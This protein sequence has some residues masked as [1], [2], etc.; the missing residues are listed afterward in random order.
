MQSLNNMRY[1]EAITRRGTRCT[2]LKGANCNY[3][4]QHR[5][6]SQENIEPSVAQS[7]STLL[8]VSEISTIK[9]HLVRQLE[10][11]QTKCTSLV[12]E[13]AITQ[14]KIQKLATACE[15]LRWLAENGGDTVFEFMFA[16]DGLL[17]KLRENQENLQQ[18]LRPA[19]T[20][21]VQSLNNLGELLRCD[22][23]KIF[24]KQT[25]NFYCSICLEDCVPN[26]TD[27]ALHCNHAFHLNCI[28]LHFERKL[29]CPNCRL[30]LNINRRIANYRRNDASVRIAFIR[31]VQH[32]T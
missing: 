5:S 3:C 31:R 22:W 9:T 4:Y 26:E 25:E 6:R 23:N 29:N 1:C 10:S 18:N 14:L 30:S 7:A 32:N 15:S 8:T 13:L 28:M 24:K 17:V 12:D 19:Y 16:Y 2:R 20:D 27:Y 21:I 11:L